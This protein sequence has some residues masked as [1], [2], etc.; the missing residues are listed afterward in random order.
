MGAEETFGLSLNEVLRRPKSSGTV[1][2]SVARTGPTTRTVLPAP[3]GP[4]RVSIPLWLH[5]MSNAYWE[6]LD[7]DLPP[8]PKTALSGWQRWIDTARESPEDIM[9]PAEAPLVSGAQYRVSPRSMVGLSRHFSRGLVAPRGWAGPVRRLPGLLLLRRHHQAHP[10]NSGRA[11]R[12]TFGCGKVTRR[13]SRRGF[14][15]LLSNVRREC[16]IPRPLLPELCYTVNP[17]PIRPTEVG[18]PRWL[19]PAG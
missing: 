8:V 5:L 6:A 16:G 7:F 2:G 19:R 9:E 15:A 10:Q 4:A 13:V 3:C 14:Q 17:S 1:S 11:S 12:L 18:C